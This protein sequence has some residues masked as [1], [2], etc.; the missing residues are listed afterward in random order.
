V[1]AALYAMSANVHA[2]LEMARQEASERGWWAPYRLPN[3]L[4]NYVGMEAD[5]VAARNFELEL[6][7]GLLQTEAVARALHEQSSLLVPPGQVERWVSARMKRQER[8]AGE[9]PLRL[10]AIISE[11]ALRR[12]NGSEQAV[13]QFRHLITAAAKQHITVQVLPF[14]AGIHPSMAGGFTCLEFPPEVSAPVGW[15]EYAIGGQMIDDQKHVT[16]LGLLFDQLA[17]RALSPDESVR[18][19]KEWI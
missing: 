6:I 19:I 3:P 11:G 4:Q 15:L 17:E 10:H 12:L 13:E 1:L 9:T 2:Q 7:P 14:S 8:L 5:A 16:R 18:Y